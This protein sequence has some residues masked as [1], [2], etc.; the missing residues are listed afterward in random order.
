MEEKLYVSRTAEQGAGKPNHA[1]KMGHSKSNGPSL[2]LPTT[3]KYLR[4]SVRI[5][6]TLW[7]AFRPRGGIVLLLRSA[8]LLLRSTVLL[9]RSTVL[10]LRRRLSTLLLSWSTL[11]LCDGPI[12]STHVSVIGSWPVVRPI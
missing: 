11:M 8:V 3:A 9:L 6:P 12:R 10:L 5:V 2:K 7:L 1:K 4:L